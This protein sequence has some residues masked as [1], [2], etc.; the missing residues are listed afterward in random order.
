MLKN[1]PKLKGVG[2]YEN[3][4]GIVHRLDREASGVMVIAKNQKMFDHLKNQFKKRETE[5]EYSVLVHGK[6]ENDHGEIDFDIDRSKDGR[7]AS[8]PKTNR[9]SLRTI[10][11]I[12]FGKDALTEFWI[13][14]RFARYT[15]L[16]VQ[17]HTGRT[18][19]IRVHM[20][21][22]NHPVVGD[23]LYFNKKLNMTRDKELGRLFLHASHLCFRDLK[24]KKVC[25]EL[26]LPSELD[27]FLGELK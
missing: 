11:K 9:L 22:F 1:Y 21:A 16:K 23:T 7:M 18:H 15:L 19:Q 24:D 17:I 3:R 4:P 27:K 20:L 8:R 12:Q 26:K 2:E 14:R 10:M 25:F 13:E 5:K 6:I